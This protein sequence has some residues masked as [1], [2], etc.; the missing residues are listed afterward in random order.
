LE[1]VA[2]FELTMMAPLFAPMSLLSGHLT[3]DFLYPLGGTA[4]MVTVSE[5]SGYEV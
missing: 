3:P 4:S 1:S 2:I 5:G